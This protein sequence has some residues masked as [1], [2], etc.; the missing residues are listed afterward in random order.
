MQISLSGEKVISGNSSVPER[1]LLSN[2]NFLYKFRLL[3]TKGNFYS[4]FRT[5]LVSAVSQNNQLKIIFMPKRLILGCHVLSFT[6]VVEGQGS[7]LWLLL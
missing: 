7:S 2:A 3:L 1:R 5:P 4:I 6:H